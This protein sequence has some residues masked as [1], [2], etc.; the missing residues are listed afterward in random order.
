M[1]GETSFLRVLAASVRARI[2]AAASFFDG[3]SARST[4]GSTSSKAV[5]SVMVCFTFRSFLRVEEIDWLSSCGSGMPCHLALVI[6]DDSFFAGPTNIS[7]TKQRVIEALGECAGVGEAGGGEQVVV[8]SAEGVGCL[9][10]EG[11]KA[12]AEQQAEGVRV[13]VEGRAVGVAFD[14]PRIFRE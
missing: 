6:L 8:L 14:R 7:C 13:V 5:R 9:L 3:S 4:V 12:E 1:N 11:V 10:V 2:K